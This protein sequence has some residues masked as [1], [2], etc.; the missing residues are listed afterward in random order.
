M[1]RQRKPKGLKWQLKQ[2]WEAAKYATHK[3]LRVVLYVATAG[4]TLG[5]QQAG[6]HVYLQQNTVKAIAQ[7]II[8]LLA[9]AGYNVHDLTQNQVVTAFIVTNLILVWVAKFIIKYYKL[10]GKD[11]KKSFI[12]DFY[13]LV[14]QALNSKSKK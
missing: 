2:F 9:Q 3:T 8:E 10:I 14:K 13:L 11:Y 5:L 1:A 6:E 7:Y 12:Y 4:L